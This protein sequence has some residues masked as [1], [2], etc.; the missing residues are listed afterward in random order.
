MCGLLEE[1]MDARDDHDGEQGTC[2][3]DLYSADAASVCSVIPQALRLLIDLG[4]LQTRYGIVIS[5]SMALGE[6]KMSRR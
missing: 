6:E 2:C 4:S 3:L 1:E 5:I